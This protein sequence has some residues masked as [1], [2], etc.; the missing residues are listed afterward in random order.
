MGFANLLLPSLNDLGEFVIRVNGRVQLAIS[1]GAIPLDAG[2][3][4]LPDY[5]GTADSEL[6]EFDRKMRSAVWVR[7]SDAVVGDILTGAKRWE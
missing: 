7:R 3:S 6:P 4:G 1:R 5:F 2:D